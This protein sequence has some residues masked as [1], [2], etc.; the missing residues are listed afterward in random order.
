[1]DLDTEFQKFC[2]AEYKRVMAMLSRKIYL[3]LN[4][5]KINAYNRN[6]YNCNKEDINAT[7]RLKYKYQKLMERAKAI[8]ILYSG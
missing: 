6:Y 3:S 8:D 2:D 7:R 4:R 1:M 5:E